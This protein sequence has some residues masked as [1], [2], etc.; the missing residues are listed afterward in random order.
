MSRST[1]DRHELEDRLRSALRARAGTTAVEPPERFV[2]GPTVRTD[3]PP[4]RRVLVVAAAAVVAGVLAIGAVALARDDSSGVTTGP[5]TSAEE[6]RAVHGPSGSRW[7]VLDLPDVTP[8]GADVEDRGGD[9]VLGPNRSFQAFRTADGFAGPSLWVEGIPAGT[10]LDSG[11]DPPGSTRTTIQ[12]RDAMVGE[13]DGSV[14][15]TWPPGGADEGFDITAIGI[16]ADEV[17]AFAEGLRPRGDGQG[18]DATDLPGGLAEIPLDGET[19]SDARYA[20]W[21]YTDP[22]DGNYELSVNPGGAPVFEDWVREH[23]DGGGTVTPITVDG[24]PGVVVQTESELVA[25][26]RPTDTVV[27]DFRVTGTVDD[28][29]T[30]LE[31]LLPV[32]EAAWLD[33]LPPDRR[34][35]MPG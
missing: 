29:V 1:I 5:P 25:V 4:S 13:V 20:E 6:G 8:T 16:D 22:L 14:T 34:P 31:A 23:V 3:T 15:L 10:G 26:W 18:W 32:D 21:S 35:Q 12:G 33:H 9:S 24:R 27:A 7:F 28:M 30:D 11:D 2:P 19:P 17:V